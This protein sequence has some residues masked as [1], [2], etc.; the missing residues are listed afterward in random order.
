MTPRSIRL[1]AV[2]AVV[3]VTISACGDDDGS[4]NTDA[5]QFCAG[6]ADLA[7][8]PDG[9]DEANVAVLR[10]IGATAPSE[11]SDEWDALVD[12][13]EALQTA[14]LESATEDDLADFE[15]TLADFEAANVAVEAFALEN[16]PELPP[17]FFATD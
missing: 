13:F 14:D 5:T 12:G 10:E 8:T 3:A 4:E 1:S 9:G 7:D 15:E 2:L 17:Q 6:L 11:I 16:C